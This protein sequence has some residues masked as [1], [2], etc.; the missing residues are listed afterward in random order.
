MF[1]MHLQRLGI[2]GLAIALVSVALAGAMASRPVAA[3]Q[4]AS[5]AD[6]PTP[7]TLEMGPL[8]TL[9]SGDTSQSQA[10]TQVVAAKRFDPRLGLP[11]WLHAVRDVALWSGADDSARTF[12]S[13]PAGIGYVKPLGPFG[14][15]R[16]EVYFPG[17]IDHPAAQAWVDLTAVEPAGVPAW[18]APLESSPTT[19]PPQRTGDASVPDATAIHIA[20]VDDASGQ[21][22]YSELP[23]TEV[24]QASTTKIATTIVALER[25]P[26]L[27]QRISVTV[28]A[29]AMVARDGS[30]T[31]GIEPG[32]TVSLDTLLHGMML[33]SGNDA[34]E[35]VAVALAGSRQVYVD[36]MNQEAAS[37][38]LKNTH[39]VNPSGMDA[40]GH[41]SSA[42]DMAML[43]RYAMHNATFRDLASAT[44]YTGDGYRMSNLN[45]LLAL[46]PGADGVK[47]GFTDE[48]HKTIVASAVRGG[49]R[50]Y[51][52]LMH[53]EDLVGDCSSLFN[54]V[55][56][57]FS[58]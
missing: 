35:Q 19:A 9:T 54:W 28:S 34:A 30:T 49:H 10:S 5:S 37:L 29:S 4:T 50:V 16:I 12:D 24:P 31:M 3:G 20:I 27:K 23:Y 33:P 2:H 8:P 47:I 39:F 1:R 57:N 40:A 14:D 32:R 41:Y 15:S 36:W 45:R 38:A 17:D 44:T 21:L 51:V 43:A 46:Y 53:S 48:A 7:A 42:Y 56:A 52:S 25:A 55:W 22:M 13:V 18:I 6:Q 26:D 11:Q 58:W